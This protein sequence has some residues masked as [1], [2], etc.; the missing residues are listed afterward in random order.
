MAG[1]LG[2]SSGDALRCPHINNSVEE[3]HLESTEI[4]HTKMQKETGD[5]EGVTAK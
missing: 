1:I 3:V 5:A 2:C 4:T